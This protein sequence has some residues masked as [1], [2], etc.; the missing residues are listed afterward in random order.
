MLS[1]LSDTIDKKGD[2]SCTKRYRGRMFELFLYLQ[3][4]R[5]GR[6]LHAPPPESVPFEGDCAKTRSDVFSEEGG[7]SVSVLT[8]SKPV[9]R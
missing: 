8:P 2:S 9:P 4:R 6:H 7:E 1:I 3:P 5:S